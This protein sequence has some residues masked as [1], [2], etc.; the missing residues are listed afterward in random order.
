MGWKTE[1]GLVTSKKYLA[2]TR[3][4]TLSS[5]TFPVDETIQT[6]SVN[7]TPYSTTR[8]FNAAAIIAC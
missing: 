6:S 1:E 2:I 4:E 8:T 7:P 5:A 3:E